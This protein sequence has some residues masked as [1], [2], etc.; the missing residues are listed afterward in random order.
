MV[1]GWDCCVSAAEIMGDGL[2]IDLGSM[3]RPEQTRVGLVMHAL[4]WRAVRIG[5][6]ANR[7]RGYRPSAAYL[8]GLEASPDQAK[9]VPGNPWSTPSTQPQGAWQGASSQGTSQGTSSWGATSGHGHGDG[10]AP[11]S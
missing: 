4:Q 9:P 11:E 10:W 1:W 3:K 5:R 8:R 7:S 2:K 6:G